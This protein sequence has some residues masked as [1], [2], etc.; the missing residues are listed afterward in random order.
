MGNSWSS[1]KWEGVSAVAYLVLYAKKWD[2]TLN[3]GPEEL[4]EALSQ[5]KAGMPSRVDSQSKE[6]L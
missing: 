5:K 6:S 4:S 3:L 1:R 2:Q